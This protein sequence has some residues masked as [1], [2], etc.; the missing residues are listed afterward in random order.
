MQIKLEG[1]ICENAQI[2]TSAQILLQHYKE[3][4][5]NIT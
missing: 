2:F 3:G 4:D 5:A 1:K